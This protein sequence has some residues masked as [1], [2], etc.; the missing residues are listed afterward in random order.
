[1]GDFSSNIILTTS[2]TQATQSCCFF[3]STFENWIARWTVLWPDILRIDNPFSIVFH[4]RIWQML[5]SRKNFFSKQTCKGTNLQIY[6]TSY[7]TLNSELSGGTKQMESI[8]NNVMHPSEL[9]C[10]IIRTWGKTQAVCRSSYLPKMM[11]IEK[12]KCSP[13]KTWVYISVSKSL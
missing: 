9:K 8:Y 6:V 2:H 13:L 12:L 3:S 4:L 1:M 7:V 11:D 5:V 10:N